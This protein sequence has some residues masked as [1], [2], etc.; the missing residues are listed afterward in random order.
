VLLRV[1]IGEQRFFWESRPRL[2]LLCLVRSRPGRVCCSRLVQLR[3]GRQ[4]G[5]EAFSPSRLDGCLCSPPEAFDP[6]GPLCSED[7]RP[8]RVAT[9]YF[10]LATAGGVRI[11]SRRSQCS[12][13]LD[14]LF[15]S[16]PNA[17]HNKSEPFPCRNGGRRVGAHGRPLIGRAVRRSRIDDVSEDP[18]PKLAT[19]VVPQP[20]RWAVSS[21]LA[22][23]PPPVNLPTIS[24]A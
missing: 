11:G 8:T 19:S 15:D 4:G 10:E 2:S 20:A 24:R 18:M 6:L 13:S 12:W 21:F 23:D 17:E 14:L 3:V 16:W 1:G 5:R 9:T 7:G 22:V